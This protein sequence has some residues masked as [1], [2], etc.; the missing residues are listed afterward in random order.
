MCGWGSATPLLL[1]AVLEMVVAF[2]V[3][4][5]C[6]LT[7]LCRVNNERHAFLHSVLHWESALYKESR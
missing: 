3:D 1:A 2:A 6:F 5:S 7:W 4:H